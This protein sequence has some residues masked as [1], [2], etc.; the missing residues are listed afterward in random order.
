MNS[1]AGSNFG[2]MM[3]GNRPGGGNSKM[4]GAGGNMPFNDMQ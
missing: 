3:N 4:S 2:G 1:G